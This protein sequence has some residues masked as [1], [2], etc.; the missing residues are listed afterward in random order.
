[1]V[2][3]R[4]VSSCDPLNILINFYSYGIV[5]VYNQ[6]LPFFTKEIIKF[7]FTKTSQR[8][9]SLHTSVEQKPLKSARHLT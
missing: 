5:L 7:E 6:E 8:A 3:G 2:Y 1:M 9:H 4:N